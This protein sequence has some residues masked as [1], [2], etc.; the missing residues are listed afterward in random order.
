MT[1]I[2]AQHQDR[3]NTNHRGKKKKR[4]CI[5]LSCFSIPDVSDASPPL[6]PRSG[7]RFFA[8]YDSARKDLNKNRFPDH[9]GFFF[10]PFCKMLLTGYGVNNLAAKHEQRREEKKAGGPFED[11]CCCSCF[12]RCVCALS[13][14]LQD[15]YFH[16][17]SHKFAKLG[18]ARNSAIR[19]ARLSPTGAFCA[20]E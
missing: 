18:T 11:G 2:V 15:C 14:R 19:A 16:C 17:E 12:L 4:K 20:E 9:L 3:S 7:R 8:E 5:F 1:M 10:L 13:S 6:P